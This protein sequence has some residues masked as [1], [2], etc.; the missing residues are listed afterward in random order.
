MAVVAEVSRVSGKAENRPRV[1]EVRVP[2]IE[3]KLLKDQR[4]IEKIKKKFS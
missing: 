1:V 4:R 2:P 3:V